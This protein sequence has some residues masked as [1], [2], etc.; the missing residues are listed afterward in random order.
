MSVIV[1]ILCDMDNK[2]QYSN[3][4][5]KSFFHSQEYFKAYSNYVKSKG[6]PA[7]DLL[8]DLATSIP[9]AAFNA[10]DVALREQIDVHVIKELDKVFK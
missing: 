1:K 9:Q 8:T 7:E 10:L 3:S 5:K 4:L 2:S 6:N